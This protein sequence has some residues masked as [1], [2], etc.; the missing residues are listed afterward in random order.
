MKLKIVV[1][2]ITCFTLFSCGSIKPGVYKT[3]CELY[4]SPALILILNNDGT[5]Q[6]IRTYVDEKITGKWKREN[7]I[8]ILEADYF[9][10]QE[11]GK[12][13]PLYKFTESEGNDMYKIKGNKLLVYSSNEGYNSKC[14]LIRISDDTK[15]F[16]DYKLPK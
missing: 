8:L 14:H 9:K 3:T 16:K 1:L 7:D 10:L 12:V 4:H 5:F 13:E 6:Y 11:E 15:K 2:L